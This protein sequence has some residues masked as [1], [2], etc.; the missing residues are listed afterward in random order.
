MDLKG[1]FDRIVRLVRTRPRLFVAMAVGAVV[2]VLLPGDVATHAVTRGL[3]GWNTGVVL[4]LVLAAHMMVRSSNDHMRNRSQLEDES[5][6]VILALVVVATIA[7][8]VAIAGELVV[9]R[10]MQGF[11]KTAHVALAGV[12][13]LSSWAFIQ[14]MFT[15]HYA[16][17][18]YNAM[19]HQRTPGLQFP[20]DEEPDYGD[21][22]YF[23]SVIGT[24]GQTADVAFVSKPMRR[25]GVLHCILSY[26]FNT[27]VLALLINIGA[28]LL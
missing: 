16:H 28:S 27:T 13:V 10:N 11:V 25:I 8:L 20:G 17:D 15:L 1:Q 26:L 5:K 14:V 19:V 24:S 3:V 21:F 23:A 12:T 7:S 9:V 4:Y 2:G 6:K 18:Y 22:F